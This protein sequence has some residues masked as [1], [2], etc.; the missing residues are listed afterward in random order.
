[1]MDEDGFG[2]FILMGKIYGK[3]GVFFLRNNDYY[4]ETNGLVI[5]FV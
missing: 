5:Y 1:M 3:M 4:I 2:F